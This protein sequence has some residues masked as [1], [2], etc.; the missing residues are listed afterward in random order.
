MTATFFHIDAKDITFLKSQW[1]SLASFYSSDK[2][3]Q[4]EIFQILK[5]RYSEKSR[6]Y[7]NLSHVKTLLALLESLADKIRDLKVIKFS[8]W[9]HDVIYDT[10][11]S[12]NEAES[13]RLASEMLHKL[14]VNDETM[15]LQGLRF[16][17]AL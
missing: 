3:I 6:F 12:D 7:H 2:T 11:K 14:N 1:D 13:A 10:R 17:S 9:F 15:E 4:E 16:G 5:E 8:I